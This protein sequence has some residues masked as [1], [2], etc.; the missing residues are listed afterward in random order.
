[1]Y[2]CMRVTQVHVHVSIHICMQ[3]C[4]YIYAYPCVHVLV[5]QKQYT[6]PCICMHT[7]MHAYTHI[8]IQPYT[9]VLRTVRMLRPLRTITRIKG[10]K[11]LIQTFINSIK[12]LTSVGSVL[13]FCF[14]VFGIL[15]IDILGGSLRGR[16]YVDPLNN[17]F[18]S[19][20]LHRLRSQQVG[21][22]V[23]MYV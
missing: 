18:T 22:C 16:C 1:M 23:G 15:G 13:L 7:H 20:A 17:N 4:M 11:P 21:V 8:Y 9:Q 5:M 12:N 19:A 6:F 14:V 10:M 2:V 3:I